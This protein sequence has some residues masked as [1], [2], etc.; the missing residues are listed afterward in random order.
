MFPKHIHI[1]DSFKNSQWKWNYSFQS[2]LIKS[3]SNKIIIDKDYF[4]II[5][6][7]RKGELRDLIKYSNI[8]LKNKH[9]LYDYPISKNQKKK[10]I[11]KLRAGW[12]NIKDPNGFIFKLLRTLLQCML[13]F[14][15]IVILCLNTSFCKYTFC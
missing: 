14:L 8:I 12:F 3:I 2:Y 10:N 1:Y 15:I 4:T 6:S 9:Y 13:I 11:H 5:I 7:I